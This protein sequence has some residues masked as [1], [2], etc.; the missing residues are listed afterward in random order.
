MIQPQSNGDGPGRP[1]GFKL[2]NAVLQHFQSFHARREV[3]A[4][5]LQG[6]GFVEI[7]P[8]IG[9]EL[10]VAQIGPSPAAQPQR[11]SQH[12][13]AEGEAAGSQLAAAGVLLDQVAVG[14]NDAREQLLQEETVVGG[15]HGHRVF[16]FV[17]QRKLTRHVLAGAAGGRAFLQGAGEI[18]AP[19]DWR[20]LVRIV[21]KQRGHKG[22][23]CGLERCKLQWKSEHA[24]RQ[25]LASVK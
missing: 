23:Q 16:G 13:G 11:Q 24:R 8:H 1:V 2:F 17:G 9:S 6:N 10:A 18:K 15:H 7:G 21:F 19:K 3:A 22:A 20:K 12:C 5:A 4:L 14:K 25:R